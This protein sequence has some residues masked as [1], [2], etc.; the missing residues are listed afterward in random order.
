[1]SRVLQP[2]NPTQFPVLPGAQVITQMTMATAVNAGD[3]VYLTTSGYGVAASSGGIGS[4]YVPFAGLLT[5][6]YLQSGTLPQYQYG[7][8]AQSGTYSG[9]TYTLGQVA[10][11]P[12]SLNSVSVSSQAVGCTALT[13][14]NFVFVYRTASNTY[15]FQILS[16]SGSVV[17]AATLIASNITDGAS[18]QRFCISATQNGGFL[19]GYL[20]TSGTN[21]VVKVYTSTGTLTSTN[22]IAMAGAPSTS[23]YFLN[24]FQ[25]I[26]GNIAY[27]FGYSTSVY[28]GVVDSSFS[29]VLATGGLNSTYANNFSTSNY[30]V[31]CALVNGGF[32]LAWYDSTY[33]N[34]VQIFS[35]TGSQLIQNTASNGTLSGSNF[36]FTSIC[37]TQDG[38]FAMAWN[39][40]SSP[41]MAR[42]IYTLTAI[43]S[44]ATI[45]IDASGGSINFPS[46][47]FST[48]NDNLGVLYLNSAQYPYLAITTSSTYS[49]ST[50]GTPVALNGATVSG[51]YNVHNGS[52]SSA[53]GKGCWIFAGT[54]SYPNYVIFSTVAV[55]NGQ[56]LSG[57][58]FSPPSYLFQGVS[59]DTVSANQSA[60]VVINGTATLNSNYPSLTSVAPFDFSGT[61]QFGNRGSV[62]GRTVTMQGAQ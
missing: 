61:G 56:T 41:L 60:N 37:P 11:G 46:N 47:I 31:G 25:L 20:P 58:T 18:A 6:G 9:T 1:M 22:N 59:L 10:T 21:I 14:G 38:Y 49:S 23:S 42:F 2:V 29:V 44:A 39:N 13:G 12:T 33:S 43:A 15:Y 28:Y 51:S 48:Q 50:F 57:L 8:S 27:A 34:R 24:V 19:I 7:P 52:Y 17:A 35:N 55:T 36:R 40:G 45:T 53:S 4:Y 62:F 26:N 3:Y 5:Q 32:V 16:S 30:L 54:S